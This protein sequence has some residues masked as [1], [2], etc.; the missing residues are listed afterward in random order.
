MRDAA[1]INLK[2][3]RFSKTSTFSLHIQFCGIA[4]KQ[5]AKFFYF[6]TAPT[7]SFY[8]LKIKFFLILL[9]LKYLTL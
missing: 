1:F 3:E 7:H 2:I 6:G 8:D 9:D 4:A 5:N